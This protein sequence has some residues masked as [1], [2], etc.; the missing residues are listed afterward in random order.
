MPY[1]IVQKTVPTLPSKN[2][3]DDDIM[4]LYYKIYDISVEVLVNINLYLFNAI[5]L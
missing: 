4:T 5:I 2:I 1:N 3:V